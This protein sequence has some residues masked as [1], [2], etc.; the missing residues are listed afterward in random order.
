M[1]RLDQKQADL[2]LAAT[3]RDRHRKLCPELGDQP[4]GGL[5]HLACPNL[6]ETEIDAVLRKGGEPEALAAGGGAGASGSVA[7]MP[8]RSPRSI[9]PSLARDS[10]RAWPSGVHEKCE[11]N[12]L[13]QRPATP[14]AAL[15]ADA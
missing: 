1:T 3:A 10:R 14:T 8:A 7:L 5:I 2:R 15:A 12:S 6:S 9:A 13:G 11:L 4:L